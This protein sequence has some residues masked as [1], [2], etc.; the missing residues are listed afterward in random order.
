MAKVRLF[1]DRANLSAFF[2]RRVWHF[3]YFGGLFV[4]QWLCSGGHGVGQGGMR[5]QRATARRGMRRAR[6]RSKKTGCRFGKTRS[7]LVFSRSHLVFPRSDLVFSCLCRKPVVR[8]GAWLLSFRGDAAAG[9]GPNAAS[10]RQAFGRTGR[11]YGAD[12]GMDTGGVM[13]Q[14]VFL[15]FRLPRRFPEIEAPQNH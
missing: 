7:D 4:P 9:A 1:F 3:F 14:R 12:R 15:R 8:P 5:R 10:P 13:P 2:L 11:G 6:L